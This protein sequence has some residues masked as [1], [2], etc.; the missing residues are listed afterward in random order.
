V[1]G[2]LRDAVQLRG[3]TQL[4]AAFAL[5]GDGEAVCFVADALD[6]EQPCER[7]GSSTG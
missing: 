2:R 4:I 6:Q 7:S 1:P 5:V 3:D